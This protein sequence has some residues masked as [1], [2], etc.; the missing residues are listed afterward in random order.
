[1]IDLG[2]RESSL[3]LGDKEIMVLLGRIKFPQRDRNVLFQMVVLPRSG[4]MGSRQLRL[5][6]AN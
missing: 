5:D 6:K 3:G 2:M 4:L 1:V